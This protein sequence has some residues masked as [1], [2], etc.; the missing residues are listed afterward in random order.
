MIT[1]RIACLVCK[2]DVGISHYFSSLS[3]KAKASSPLTKWKKDFLKQIENL[4]EINFLLPE[5]DY[6]VIGLPPNNLG[7]PY[8]FEKEFKRVLIN[9]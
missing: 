9:K 8:V 5:H 2:S 7:S 3:P 4:A 6:K 1:F